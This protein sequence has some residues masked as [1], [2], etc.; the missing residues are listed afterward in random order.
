MLF[1]PLTQWFSEDL[2]CIRNMQEPLLKTQMVQSFSIQ[3][4]FSR[5]GMDPQ[6]VI[7]KKFPD[8]G[9]AAG[10]EITL[11]SAPVENS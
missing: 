1:F 11:T 2:E 6:F 7:S 10:L 3:T 8:N 9:N 5:Y 4:G